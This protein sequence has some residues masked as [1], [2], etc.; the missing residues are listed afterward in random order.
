MSKIIHDKS[1]E[2][3]LRLLEETMD[4]DIVDESLDNPA[5]DF[6]NIYKLKPGNN[7]VRS[8]VLVRLY[9]IYL[10]DHI[11]DS[12]AVRQLNEFLPFVNGNFML[13]VSSMNLNLVYLRYLSKKKLKKTTSGAYQKRF[14]DF[15]KHWNLEKGEYYLPSYALYF[16]YQVFVNDRKSKI[17]IQPG[18]FI[19]FLKINFTTK[20]LTKA[21]KWFGVD[22]Q[23]LRK[24][25]NEQQ[26]KYIEEWYASRKRI[27]PPPRRVKISSIKSIEEFKAKKE[28]D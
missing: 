9:K 20:T 16:L 11:V 14:D 5:I 4:E 18:E 17:Y 19:R 12:A 7:P 1:T 23:Q 28:S 10:K 22:K 6:I 26:E 2:E 15:C 25:L 27:K 24:T 13:D 3:L 21:E 8:R